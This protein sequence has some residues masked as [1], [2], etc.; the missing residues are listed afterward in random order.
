MPVAGGGPRVLLSS[1]DSTIKADHKRKPSTD[2]RLSSTGHRGTLSS[3]RRKNRTVK[4]AKELISSLDDTNVQA[5]TNPTIADVEEKHDA[6]SELSNPKEVPSGWHGKKVPKEKYAENGAS[7]GFDKPYNFNSCR[8]GG[9]GGDGGDGEN[10][11]GKKGKEGGSGDD[12]RGGGGGGGESSRGGGTEAVTKRLEN[13]VLEEEGE[14]DL[15]AFQNGQ[16]REASSMYSHDYEEELRRRLKAK[17]SIR[18]EFQRTGDV[19][20]RSLQFYNERHRQSE[21]NFRKLQEQK[22]EMAKKLRSPKELKLRHDDGKI[23]NSWTWKMNATDIGEHVQYKYSG[24]ELIRITNVYQ[25]CFPWSLKGSPHRYLI[26]EK[27]L[28]QRFGPKFWKITNNTV[29]S[30]HYNTQAFSAEAGHDGHRYESWKGLEERYPA[31]DTSF[32]MWSEADE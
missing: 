16:I 14:Q 1:Q 20:E 22:T 18:L 31:G 27:D 13:V 11:D 17:E 25:R 15:E 5:T 12:G 7:R 28:L 32:Y 30:I 19:E 10:G 4:T 3:S 26:W 23:T 29:D 9:D 2:N 24:A 21:W 6:V 8:G